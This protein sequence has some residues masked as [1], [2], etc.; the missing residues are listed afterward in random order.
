MKDVYTLDDLRD[1][2]F[3]TADA[4]LPIRLAVVGNPVAHSR[5]PGMHNA[6]LEKLGIP[7]RYTR[8]LV[9]P[10]E[11]H[12]MLRMLPQA[13]FIGL[14]V[15]LPHK[16]A[17]LP[18]LTKVDAAARKIGAINT[19]VVGENGTLHG[20]NTDGPGFVR[21]VRADFGVDVRDLRVMVLGAGGGAGRAISVQC[22]LEGCE[23]LV[24]V[25]RTGEKAQTL[26]SE[27]QPIIA[28]SR[29]LGPMARLEACAWQETA[30]RRQ[31]D[32]IDLIVNASSVGLKFG[33]PSPLAAPLL[34]P[35]HLIYDT[36]YT[37]AQTPFMRAAA[38]AGARAVNGL[39]MLLHQGALSFEIWFQQS[40]PLDAMRAAL[41]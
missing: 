9:R 4:P 7:A 18:L 16:T 21:A 27:L 33:D 38:E 37:T 29:L 28:S 6:A 11:L 36:I 3:A 14:N 35:S 31:L 8:L 34:R 15:T 25:N 22:A 23:R 5:S 12:E 13:G 24:L 1:W 2:P 32:N 26:A 41:A 19:V 40:A 17:L 39:S 20:F 30:L 10:E